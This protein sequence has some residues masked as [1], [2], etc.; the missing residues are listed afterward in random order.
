MSRTGTGIP[1]HMASKKSSAKAE[2]RRDRKR[3]EKAAADRRQRL[4]RVARAWG[5][6]AGVLIVLHGLIDWIDRPFWGAIETVT[7]RVTGFV[8]GLLGNDAPVVGNVV[9]SS[10]F[11]IE[12]IRE[13]TGVEPALIFVAAVAAVPVSWKA[14]LIGVA[15]GLPALFLINQIRLVSLVLIGRSMPQH[16]DM[17]HEQVWQSLMLFATAV[18][19]IAWAMR[20]SRP[21]GPGSDGPG[22][23]GPGPN[24]QEPEVA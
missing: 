16:F 9:R 19:W 12:I 17:A 22:P 8:L 4:W 13:C 6:F 21:A 15:A 10:W 5:I 3:N 20:A 7:A 18:L 1:V 24:G 2:A 11:P 14:R 23:D